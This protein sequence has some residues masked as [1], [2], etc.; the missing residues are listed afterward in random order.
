[1]TARVG[2]LSR[3]QAENWQIEHWPTTSPAARTE[4]QSLKSSHRVLPLPAFSRSLPMD[5][6]S[7]DAPS[8]RH[9]SL[10]K[11]GDYTWQ[12]PGSIALVTF[13]LV[14]YD[15]KR[16]DYWNAVPHSIRLM[17]VKGD[18]DFDTDSSPFKRELADVVFGPR[19]SSS[20]PSPSKDEASSP[21]LAAKKRTS[22]SDMKSPSKF[23]KAKTKSSK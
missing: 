6:T 5:Y 13:Q 9:W 23:K 10:I 7:T 8:W 16:N 2:T 21:S 3:E 11:P 14:H 4:L 1:V 12:L 20:V 15:M 19:A 17:S 18:G 22:S